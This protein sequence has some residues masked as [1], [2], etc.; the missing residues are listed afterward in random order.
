[1]AGSDARTS[2]S[3]SIPHEFG[4]PMLLGYLDRVDVHSVLEPSLVHSNLDVIAAHL[5]LP[6]TAVFREGPVLEAITA[7]PLHLVV[8]ILIL[9]L[10]A[11]RVYQRAYLKGRNAVDAPRTGQRS[12]CQ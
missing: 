11:S 10:S 5:P 9:V 12:C 7:L 6:H 4:S 8:A 3:V 1:M 2:A